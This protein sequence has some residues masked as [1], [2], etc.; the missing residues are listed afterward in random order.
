M[1]RRGIGA[2]LLAGVLTLG[3]TAPALADPAIPGDPQVE[4]QTEDHAPL[5][6]PVVSLPLDR[7]GGED[8]YETS[9]RISWSAFQQGAD[10]VYLARGD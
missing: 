2:A 10:T 6:D 3:L 1:R 4:E 7:L 9:A 8:R 5:A